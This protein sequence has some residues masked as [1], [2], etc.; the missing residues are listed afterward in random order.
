MFTDKP[1]LQHLRSAT[2]HPK[3]VTCPAYKC[4]MKFVSRSALVLHLEAGKCRSGVD[5]AAVNMVVRQ[6][7]TN[8]I[9]TD[10]SRLITSGTATQYY[11]SG[12]S[13]NGE[14][15]ECY[16][17]HR[18]FSS[19][20]V[21]NQ[22]LGSP[23]HQDKIYICPASTCRARFTTLSGLC[24]HIESEKCGVFK[25]RAVQETMDSVLGQMGRLTL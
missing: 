20:A 23:A 10:P 25:F 7:D 3:D 15:Y 21:L 24:Q 9:I 11:A 8:N 19:L 5:R 12:S 17:C 14:A 6:Y 1:R 22:H 13:W 16:L 2:H 18:S 4:G